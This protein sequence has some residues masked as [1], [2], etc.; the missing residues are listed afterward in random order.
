MGFPLAYEEA[1]RLNLKD[2]E[3]LYHYSSNSIK[4][5]AREERESLETKRVVLRRA[6][7][8]SGGAKRSSGETVHLK[9][10][11]EFTPV[12]T[13][14]DIKINRGDFIVLEKFIFINHVSITQVL[15]HACNSNIRLTIKSSQNDLARTIPPFSL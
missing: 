7:K 11:L 13:V 12:I 8:I 1:K 5:T 15:M 10:H 2:V 9:C 4:A 3:S 14:V 6:G